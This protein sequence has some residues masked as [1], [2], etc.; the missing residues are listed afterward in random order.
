LRI[1]REKIDQF[2]SLIVAE[3]LRRL[4]DELWCLG[5]GLH[6]LPLTQW[7]IYESGLGNQWPI[8]RNDAFNRSVFL[9]L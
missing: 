1:G 6:T 8:H 9:V 7:V 5:D 4:L 2:L 3:Q